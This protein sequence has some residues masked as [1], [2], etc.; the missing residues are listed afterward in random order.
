VAVAAA[1]AEVLMAANGGGGEAGGGGG[2]GGGGGDSHNL[3]RSSFQRNSGFKLQRGSGGMEGTVVHAFPS[4]ESSS[5]GLRPLCRKKQTIGQSKWPALYGARTEIWYRQRHL[6]T[7]PTG[8]GR[9]KVVSTLG[10]GRPKRHFLTTQGPESRS[11]LC[12]HSSFSFYS[13]LS[14]PFVIPRICSSLNSESEGPVPVPHTF[15]TK[16]DV[17]FKMN[18]GTSVRPERRMRRVCTGTLV[19]YEQTVREEDA[20]SVYRD[21]GTL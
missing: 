17:E 9:V 3:P 11:C 18:E 14:V 6:V 5:T 16:P 21:T 15:D 7:L 2:G 4:L 19:H 8:F 13:T 12:K 20:A 10:T 1:A